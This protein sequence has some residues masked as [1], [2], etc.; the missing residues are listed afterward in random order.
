MILRD[1]MMG[2]LGNVDDALLGAFFFHSSILILKMFLVTLMTT[3]TRLSKDVSGFKKF[4]LIYEA[5]LTGQNLD[6]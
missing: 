4:L 5:T 2:I 3:L 6:S 1:M